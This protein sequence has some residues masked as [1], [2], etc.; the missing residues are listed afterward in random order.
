MGHIQWICADFMKDRDLS[1]SAG[2]EFVPKSPKPSGFAEIQWIPLIVSLNL[3]IL[4]FFRVGSGFQVI[5]M[6]NG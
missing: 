2:W 5:D 4:G 6:L 3:K 1:Q